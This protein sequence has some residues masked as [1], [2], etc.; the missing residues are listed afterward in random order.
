MAIVDI[1]HFKELNDRMGHQH[2][3]K[4]LCGLTGLLSEALRAVNIVARYGGDE[5]VIAMPHTDLA[6]AMTLA[7]RLRA[8]GT[9]TGI[10]G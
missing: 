8:R 4:A 3:D 9:A 10:H 5:F 7:D 2:G 6:G 1:D